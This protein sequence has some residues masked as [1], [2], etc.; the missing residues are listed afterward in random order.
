MNSASLPAL[1]GIKI[2]ELA[3]PYT[4]YC[5]K[6]FADMGAEVVLV[7][8]PRGGKGRR[9]APFI[10]D[11]PGLERSL[12]FAY[13]NTSKRG[14]TLD[15]DAL[16]GRELFLELVAQADLV[17]EGER[18]GRLAALGLDY[19]AL[20]QARPGLVQ[21]SVTA[22]GQ[23]GPYSQF[24]CEDMV[25]VAMGGFMYLSGYPDTAPLRAYGNQAF[26]AAG[27]YASVASMLALTSAELEGAGDH[28]D[29][30]MQECVVM[31]METAVQVFDL[32]HTVRKRVGARQ[33][34]AGTGVFEC[35]D[36]YVYMMAAGIGANKFWGYSL[37]WLEEEKV[38][39]VD[40][41]QGAEWKDF[42]Y[43]QTEDAKRIF[44]E[45][46]APWAK[47]KTKAYLYNGGQ[48]RHIPLAAV[49]TP[50][51]ILDNPQLEYRGYFVDV[52]HPETQKKLR[53]PGAPFR[54]SRTPWKM[55]RRAPLLGE[56]NAEV[57]GALGRDGETL[58]RL[59][60]AGVI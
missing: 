4:R 24:E 34:Y 50:Q 20:A 59:H 25:G 43:I 57:Y 56:H 38:P 19:D 23:T 60:S 7:E 17:L 29:V 28:L 58:A 18:P 9:E 26:L 44:A 13:Y 31:A 46:F 48:K 3:S 8:P 49:N 22:F 55:Q 6:L 37:G 40:R 2:V 53:M 16:R 11:R 30:S 35:A 15:L 36:G 32:E 5:G 51:D 47:T 1:R 41:L 12:S 14:V 33:R 45:V 52:E 54:L 21:T 42:E 39:G 10:D 27:T